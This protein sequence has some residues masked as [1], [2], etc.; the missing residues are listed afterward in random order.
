MKTGKNGLIIGIIYIII[1]ALTAIGPN[2]IFAVCEAMEGKFMRCHWTARAEIGV[3]AVIAILGILFIIFADER[4]RT[5]I[6]FALILFSTQILLLPDLLIGVCGKSHMRCR[7]LTLPALN[8]IGIFGIVIGVI[9]LVF[10]FKKR[11]GI[12]SHE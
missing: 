10:V 12:Q 1:G 3:G 4:I 11:K 5:G 8:I 9:N 6:Q 2:S 7:S